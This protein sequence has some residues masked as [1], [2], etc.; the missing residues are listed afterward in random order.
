[1]LYLKKI[2][3]GSNLLIVSWTEVILNKSKSWVASSGKTTQYFQ[4][5]RGTWQ[6]D[7]V[8]AYLFFSNGSVIYSD[9]E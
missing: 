6:G 3:F 1:M 9:K 2:G 8:S 7:P 4:L 5:N